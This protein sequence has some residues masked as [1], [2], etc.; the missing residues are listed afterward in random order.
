MSLTFDRELSCKFFSQNEFPD[1]FSTFT[2]KGEATRLLLKSQGLKIPNLIF[3]CKRGPSK[4]IGQNT[5]NAS[6]VLTLFNQNMIEKTNMLRSH[7]VFT[8]TVS[9]YYGNDLKRADLSRL[10]SSVWTHNE[11]TALRSWTWTGWRDSPRNEKAKKVSP[12]KCVLRQANNSSILVHH[13]L[14]PRILKK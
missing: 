6:V 4:Q 2:A 8:K 1:L 10:C 3:F 13:I 11:T 7:A 9:Y 14:Y 5:Q 12:K